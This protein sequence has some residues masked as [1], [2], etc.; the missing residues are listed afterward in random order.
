MH[1]IRIHILAEWDTV[2]AVRSF[3]PGKRK[4][5]FVHNE[6]PPNVNH[7]F[8]AVSLHEKRKSFR[9]LFWEKAHPETR[10]EQRAFVGCHSDIGGGLANPGLS[11]LSLLWM[12]S[13]IYDVSKAKF[14]DND[15]FPF[16]VPLKSRK[17]GN[18]FNPLTWGKFEMRLNNLTTTEGRSVDPL[19]CGFVADCLLDKHR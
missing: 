16:I 4:F 11:T 12:V 5:A 17:A 19:S 7:A 8:H 9:P 14:T 18:I 13:R 10:V 2:S 1:P 6:V 15:L 3:R